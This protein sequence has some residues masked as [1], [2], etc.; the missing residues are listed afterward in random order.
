MK[1]KEINLQRYGP[2]AGCQFEKLGCF[3]LFWG[4]NED[5]KTLVIEALIKIFFGKK[6]KEFEGINRV[7]E[8]PQGYIVLETENSREI[9]LPR[10][11]SLTELIELSPLEAKNIFIIRNSELFFSRDSQSELLFFSEFTDRLLGLQTKKLEKIKKALQ[12]IGR[13]TRADSTADLSDNKDMDKIQSRMKKAR[14]VIEKIDQL[15]VQIK[16]EGWADLEKLLAT[17]EERRD[18]LRHQL[19]QLEAARRRELYQE[20]KQSLENLKKSQATIKELQGFEPSL[21]R[22]WIEARKEIE[23]FDKELAKDQQ[24]L[25]RK[26]SLINLKEEEE[27][28]KKRQKEVLQTKQAQTQAQL[29]E[30]VNE[31][32]EKMMKLAAGETR[33]SLFFKLMIGGFTLAVMAI[34]AWLIKSHQ[35]FPWLSLFGVLVFLGSGAK[36]LWLL[37]R[38]A[39]VKSL[40]VKIAHRAAGLGYSASQI[41]ELLP[42]LA[43]LEN[44]INQLEKEVIHLEGEKR[45]LVGDVQG[46]QKKIDE[47]QQRISEKEKLISEIRRMCQVSSVE[48][49]R[50]R[51]QLL[52]RTKTQAAQAQAFLERNFGRQSNEINSNLRYWE[53]QVQELAEYKAKSVE[54]AYSEE[55]KTRLEKEIQAIEE[56][57]S[58]SEGKL[59]NFR[60]ELIN[61]ETKINREIR[62][63]SSLDFRCGTIVEMRALR[64]KLTEFVNEVEENKRIVQLILEIFEEIEVEEKNKISLLFGQQSPVSQYY[65][66]ITENKYRDVVYDQEN[67]SIVV[68][69]GSGQKLKAFQLSAGAFDQLYLAIRLALGEAKFAQEKAFFILDDPFIKS[70]PRRLL[71]QI[72][73]LKKMVE[74]GWQILYFSAKGEMKE[75]LAEDIRKQKVNFYTL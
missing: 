70:D 40:W 36:I 15:E 47:W 44:Q 6:I 59:K 9:V 75:A 31:Y 67:L 46:L 38:R 13:L 29:K 65:Q 41:E 53:Q 21:E 73:L 10:D 50:E 58:G 14:E 37:A 49:L 11:G 4:E 12:K 26:K 16:Q 56:E 19:S 33:F 5:G 28:K 24:E 74:M 68:K 66:E 34:L 72:R 64:D 45:Q 27:K 30:L 61:L 23:I 17:L 52:E 8:K 60:Q 43:H 3:N 69:T 57:I 54:V 62:L 25:R 71:N 1:I 22:D 32:Q 48:E 39:K 2:L 55:E 42:Q 7:E 35:L 51:I 18:R 20:G 63:P